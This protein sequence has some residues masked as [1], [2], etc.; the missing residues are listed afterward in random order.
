MIHQLEPP[1]GIDLP[2]S[3][4]L[5]SVL[6]SKRANWLGGPIQQGEFK[7]FEGSIEALADIARA[8]LLFQRVTGFLRPVCEVR[9]VSSVGVLTSSEEPQVLAPG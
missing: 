4:R 3:R 5:F 2:W 9:V 6:D 1:L 8:W 7:G